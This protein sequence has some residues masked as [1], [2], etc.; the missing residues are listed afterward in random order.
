VNNFY[1][2]F[3]KIVIIFETKVI[4]LIFFEIFRKLKK[5]YQKLFKN[6]L[7]LFNVSRAASSWY[8]YEKMQMIVVKNKART[9]K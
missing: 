5:L 1:L 6:N 3:V 8:F 9:E 7:I 2:D 4:K